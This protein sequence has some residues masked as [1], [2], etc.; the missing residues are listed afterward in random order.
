VSEMASTA[1]RSAAASG[2]AVSQLVG[3]MAGITESS[4]RITDIIGVIDGIAFQTNILAL[5]AAVEA[6]RAG[7]QGRGFAVVA[8]EV[9]SLAQRSAEAAK[10]IKGLIGESAGT[11]AEGSKLV[12]ETTATI[13]EAAT[14]IVSVST[15]IGEIAR[16]SAEQSTG[17][18]EIGKAIQQLEGVTQ[19]NAALVE[20]AGAAALAFEEE[21]GR[22]L[23]AV[24]AF[25]VDR[26]EARDRAMELV[27]SGITHLG[28]VGAETAFNDFENRG[29]EFI[30]GDYYLWVC[31]LN[32]IVH[33]NGSNP[34]SR[35]QN[36]ANLKDSHGKL[37]IQDVLRISRE[38]G[39]GWVDYY[40]RN[41]VS[42]QDEPKSTYFERSGDL[43]LLCGIYRAEAGAGLARKKQ[44]D[45][46]AKRLLSAA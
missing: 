32:G 29:G 23:E 27:R 14:S 41:P 26:S 20:Q 24:G 42:K 10:E 38:R 45:A 46:P 9:R 3:T 43:I 12:E 44:P 39:R 37:F 22:L 30:K 4:R 1:S 25:K 40:W 34:K 21:A 8:A 2:D 17:V 11:V 19:Q 7:E 28:A 16:A 5:N 18:D 33:A 15:V 6:A 31:D 13:A 36:Y 35:N